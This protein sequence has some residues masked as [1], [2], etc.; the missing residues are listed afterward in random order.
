M[1]SLTIGLIVFATIF[2]SGL[3]G[4]IVQR[5][6]LNRLGSGEKEVARLVTGLM[7]TMAAIVLGM[8]VSS[9]KS[10]YDARVNEV[11]AISSQV[12]TIDQL[13]ARYGNETGE[14]R[15]QFRQVVEDGM[16]RIWPTEAP[17]R[18]EPRQQSTGD[19]LTYQLEHLTPTNDAQ[20]HLKNQTLQLVLEL[21]E[22][23]WLLF[24]KSRQSA[25]PLPLLVV[26]VSWLALIFFSFGLFVQPSPT[27]VVTLAVGA[28]AVSTAIS[29]I[30]ALYTPFRGVLR[31]SPTP[32]LEALSK[33][34]G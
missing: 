1:N 19:A 16:R 2:A 5:A 23:Q 17:L 8:L 13:L 28:L 34:G 31:I 26:V 22:T 9:A 15:S 11:A 18:I 7:T 27:I 6:L 24:L 25:V 32:I 30:L 12:V 20:T 4:L 29:I 33:M 10:S 3:V 14:I 21:Q